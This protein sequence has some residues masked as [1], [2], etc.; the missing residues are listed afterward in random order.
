M[1]IAPFLL[2]AALMA[3]SSTGEVPLYKT[4]FDQI[5][6]G[7]KDKP[8]GT[9]KTPPR[10][11]IERLNVAMIQFNL[12]G[13]KIWPIM[14]PV[15]RNGD[16]VTYANQFR[17]L[18]TLRESQIVATRG[19]GRD[20]ISAASSANDPLRVLTPP[21]DWPASL[22]REYRFAGEGPEGM[23]ETYECTLTRGGAAQIAIAG[24]TFDVVGFAEAC[25]GRLDE[26]QNLYAAD[27]QTGRVWQSRQYVGKGAPA[28][29]LDILEPLTAN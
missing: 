1:R 3:C 14:T 20:L 19:L 25:K 15:S 17:Q 23:L 12:E 4:I 21:G 22:S 10:A 5:R 11:E 26:F 6:A 29:N 16:A 18:V 27:A 2:C 8:D 7:G 9:K 24:T 13:E 28:V